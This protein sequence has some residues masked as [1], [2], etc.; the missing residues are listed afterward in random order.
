[1]KFT[2]KDLEA[3]EELEKSFS[4]VR[5]IE[6]YDKELVKDTDTIEDIVKKAITVDRFKV[7]TTVY[8]GSHKVQTIGVELGI[9]GGASSRSLSDLYKLVKKY[10]PEVKLVDIVKY[11]TTLRAKGELYSTFCSQHKKNMFRLYTDIYGTNEMKK[12]RAHFNNISF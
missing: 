6:F 3:I 8:R 4:K 2:K 7:P 9:P 11:L 5:L 12:R 10:K 1:M